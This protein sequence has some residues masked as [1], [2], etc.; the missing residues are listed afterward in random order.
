MGEVLRSFGYHF[1]NYLYR[2]LKKNA[3]YQSRHFGALI[4]L[5]NEKIT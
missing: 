5:K 3:M 4:M 1:N 2:G